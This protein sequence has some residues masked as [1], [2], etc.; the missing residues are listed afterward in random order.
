ML[1]RP[2]LP[3]VQ[4]CPMGEQSGW[5]TRQQAIER[6]RDGLSIPLGAAHAEF[7]AAVASDAIGILYLNDKFFEPAY[8][9]YNEDDLAYWIKQRAIALGHSPASARPAARKLFN[10]RSAYDFAQNYISK[11]KSA[12]EVPSMSDYEEATKA[13][14]Y[15]GKRALRRDS[16]KR[17]AAALGVEV[18][19]GHP[20]RHR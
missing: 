13:A 7:E 12:S 16:Y 9:R 4:R 3:A 14:G 1:P 10:D 20:K 2:L 19:V 17:A 18:R 11:K 8:R 6:I 5:I 15:S